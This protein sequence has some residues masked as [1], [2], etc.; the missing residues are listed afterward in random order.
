M[1][2]KQVDTD[3]PVRS[4]KEAFSSFG[5]LAEVKHAS[6]SKGIIE[7]DFRPV[8]T[9]RQ[10]ERGG[11]KA[12]SVLTDETYFRGSVEILRRVR[13]QVSLPVLRKDFILHPLQVW[14][15]KQIGADAI[16]LIVAILS[17]QELRELSRLA[18]QLGLEVLVEVHDREEIDAAL[19][20][21]AEV[22]AA[23]DVDGMRADLVTAKTAVA[24]AAWE[25]RS[26]VTRED[27]AVAAKLALPHRRRGGPHLHAALHSPQGAARQHLRGQAVAVARSVDHHAH[28][29]HGHAPAGAR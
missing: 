6:P 16:L 28:A 27:I 20:A 15:S 21:I 1:A 23:F 26:E 18:H 9:A 12:I 29:G 19:V 25:G 11:A 4:L 17:A 13:Q 7:K 5:I 8:E 10:Y 3:K 14:E 22:C 24:H 2:L